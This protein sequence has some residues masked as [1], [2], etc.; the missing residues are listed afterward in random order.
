MKQVFVN[1][2]PALNST[3]C[4]D[5]TQ[6][7]HL[8][9]VLRTSPKETIRVVADGSVFLA[10]TAGKPNLFIFSQES[11]EPRLVDITLCAALIKQDKFEWMLQKAAELG[12]TRIVPFTSRN[13]IV[14]I[15]PRKQQRKLER[16][17]AIL[18]AACA[19]SNRHDA[20]MLEPVSRLQDLT[21]Y[22]SRCNVCAYEKEDSR[23]L[24][25]LLQDNPSSI[26]AVIGPEGGFDAAEAKWLEDN[27]FALCT[28]GSQILRAETAACYILSAIEYQ[29]QLFKLI[30]KEEAQ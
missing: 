28:L 22:K 12:V 23:H 16:W 15:D 5:E 21:E 30:Q 4:L 7:H 2:A 9:D 6:A 13:T 10:H 19:Q 8:F 24:C 25:A 14:A 11:V 3:I 26:T 27:G 1:S 18:E 17:Q 20:V 29:Q